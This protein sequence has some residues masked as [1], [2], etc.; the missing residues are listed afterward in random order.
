[1]HFTLECYKNVYSKK[2]PIKITLIHQFDVKY[3]IIAVTRGTC[4]SDTRAYFHLFTFL[5]VSTTDNSKKN[6]NNRQQR[7]IISLATFFPFFLCSCRRLRCRHR[8]LKVIFLLKNLLV[9]SR[10]Q[11]RCFPVFANDN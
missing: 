3:T 9:F 10:Q 11:L 4:V 5:R 7:V 1:M 2:I 6:S 8:N